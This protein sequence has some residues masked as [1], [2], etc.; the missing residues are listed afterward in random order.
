MPQPCEVKTALL[1]GREFEM[2]KRKLPEACVFPG[3]LPCFAV[4][5]LQVFALAIPILDPSPL[6]L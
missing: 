1:S 5:V 2:V 4:S 6:E 3:G